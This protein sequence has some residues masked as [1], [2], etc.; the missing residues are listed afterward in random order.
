[1]RNAESRSFP[2]IVPPRG[3][4]DLSGFTSY[5]SSISATLVVDATGFVGSDSGRGVGSLSKYA[6]HCSCHERG[7]AAHPSRVSTATVPSRCR[8]STRRMPSSENVVTSFHERTVS[9]TSRP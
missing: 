4:S 5:R 7:F 6:S 8:R 3:T 9:A 1:M 2:A